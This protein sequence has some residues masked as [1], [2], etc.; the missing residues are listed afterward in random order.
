MDCLTVSIHSKMTS[1]SIDSSGWGH[2]ILMPGSTRYCALVEN[3]GS[4]IRF[5]ESIFSAKIEDADFPD[6]LDLNS[7]IVFHATI[8]NSIS[9]NI[10]RPVRIELI[11]DG[12]VKGWSQWVDAALGPEGTMDL[13]LRVDNWTWKEESTTHAGDYLLCLSMRNTYGNIWIPMGHG[14]KVIVLDSAA[15]DDVKDEGNSRDAIYDLHGRK[16]SD[17]INSLAPGVYIKVNEGTVSKII[18]PFK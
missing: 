1:I 8:C 15:I 4:D 16:M 2:G 13:L 5:I 11:Q 7:S 14:K 17:D 10:E 12:I 3:K 9:R 6:E 18:L